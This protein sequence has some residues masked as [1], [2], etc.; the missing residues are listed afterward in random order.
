[1][2]IRKLLQRIG[3]AIGIVIILGYGF[4]AFKGMVWGPRITLNGSLNGSATTSPLVMISGRAIRI[5]RLFLNGAT[6]T[7]DLAGNF[8]ESLLL[9]R[10]YNIMTLEGFDKYGQGT[11]EVIEMTLSVVATS[12]RDI[13]TST[14]EEIKTEIE[15]LF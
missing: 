6:T 11:K 1:M 13:T 5:T 10:G 7:L 15:K 12:T 9:S 14:T 8:S 2:E 4:F 3:V